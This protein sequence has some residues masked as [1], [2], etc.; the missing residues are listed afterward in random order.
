MEFSQMTIL[1]GDNSVGKSSV[2][3]A[4]VFL[5]YCCDRTV[6]EYLRD[7]GGSAEDIATRGL[8][9]IKKIMTFRVIFQSNRS[10][11]KLDWEITF[12]VE[13]ANDRI[14]LRSEEVR[15]GGTSLL[16]YKSNGGH[17]VRQ[18]GM[19]DVLPPGDYS[20]S[21][22]AFVDEKNADARLV[23]IKHFFRETEPLDLL[24]PRDMR[25]S[26]RS[27]ARTLGTSGEK[28]PVLIQQL[29]ATEKT[30]L[31]QALK[32][33]LPH[34]KEIKAVSKRAGWTHL[35]LEEA[36]GGRMINISSVGLSDG[37]LRL[38]ALFSLKFLHKSGGITLLDEIEDGIS[39]QNIEEFL[40]HIRAYAQEQNQQI[41]MTT[42]STVLLDYAQP[43]EIRYMYRNQEGDVRCRRFEELDD[44]AEELEYL[45]PGEILLN[46]SGKDLVQESCND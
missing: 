6:G 5:Q 14:R 8:S 3:Q 18:D 36:F 15:C 13:K 1:V 33:V 20:C 11:E 24:T 46:R 29:N 22:L 27:K 43:D 42:H 32:K 45:Y 23:A 17:R 30:E 12:L 10:E 38:L 26:V 4:L 37:A 21:Q 41:L 31:E 39:P 40:A 16:S 35:E 44:V 25:K 19:Q 9:K 34:L 7:R 2:L 28:L